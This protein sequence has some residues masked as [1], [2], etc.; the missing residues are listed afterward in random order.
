VSTPALDRKHLIERRIWRLGY[1]LNGDAAG[2]SSL[3]DRVVRTRPDV[4]EMDPAKLDRLII[5]HARE[6]PRRGISGEGAGVSPERATSEALAVVLALP[7]QPR[8]AWVLTHIDSLD[9]LHVSRAMDCS[10]TAARNHLGAAEQQVK[11]RL[12]ERL[13]E[14]VAA[15]RRF[16]DSLDPGSIIERHRAERRARA[17]RKAMVVLIAAGFVVL[18]GAYVALQMLT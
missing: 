18:I 17:K 15:I 9:E 16:A 7:E 6:L 8:E 1:L 12:G 11:S 5:Q 10:R 4:V 13:P 3:V 2:A 14:A